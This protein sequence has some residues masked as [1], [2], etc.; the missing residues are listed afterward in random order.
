[1]A[2]RHGR[3]RRRLG[4][5]EEEVRRE[6]E[7]LREE[8]AATIRRRVLAEKRSEVERAVDAVGEFVEAAQRVSLA[9]FAEAEAVES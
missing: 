2:E 5:G 4:W 3:Q 6:F 1:M 7:I 8:L 9:G